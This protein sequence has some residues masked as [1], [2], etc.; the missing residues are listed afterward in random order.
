MPIPYS[1]KLRLATFWPA[2]AALL[3]SSV[4]AIVFLSAPLVDESAIELEQTLQLLAPV[5]PAPRAE[6]TAPD[7]ALQERLTE[8]VTGTDFRLT[9]ITTQGRVLADSARGFDTVPAMEN[10]RTRPEVVEALARGNGHSYRTSASTGEATSYAARLLNGE[11][12]TVWIAR[13]ARPTRALAGLQS[14]L[15]RLTLGA[16]VVAAVIALFVSLWL[17][18]SLFR[19]LSA[20]IDDADRIA[21]DGP[22]QPVAIPDVEELATLARALDRIDLEKRRRIASVEAERDHLG[23]TVASMTEGVLVVGND[24]RPQL[25]NPALRQLLG[26]APSAATADI[27]DLAR[28]PR[29]VDLIARVLE[30]G[31]AAAVEIERLEP[32]QRTLALL[33]SPL[34]GDAGVVVL[35]RDLT[36]TERLHQMRRDFV[37]NVSHE[38]KTPL[39][40]IRGYAETLV[41]GAI[42]ERDTAL[43]FSQRILDQCRRLGELLDDL[44]TLSRLESSEPS[45]ARELVGLSALSEEAIE[46]VA[47]RAAAKQISVRLEATSEIEI[48]GDSEGLLRLLSNLLDNAVK[49]NRES[50]NVTLRLE[51]RGGEA[52]LEVSDSGIGIAP[53]HLPRI[54]ERFYRVDK[55]RAREEGGTG[56]GL[57]IVKHVAQAHGGRVEVESEPGSG[58]SFRVWLPI[59][60]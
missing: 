2:L 44:L 57:A 21:G 13:L 38:L 17:T 14:R 42:D 48:P 53:T 31:E 45:R 59:P 56:L 33:G 34:A 24:G 18:R 35:A 12:G 1:P 49:Y 32:A 3:V 51:R 5:L 55:G 25:A 54:F 4:T 7:A 28:E 40:A 36:E 26:V 29:L 9:L 15:V 8:L 22:H 11:D 19:P 23:A 58:S 46:L 10:H 37:A 47:P 52:L 6:V 30:T 41:D 50:G 27:L 20:L 43:R 60:S 16:A 39:A